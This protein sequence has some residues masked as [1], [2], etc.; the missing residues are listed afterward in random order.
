MLSA[1]E[2][3]GLTPDNAHTQILGPTGPTVLGLVRVSVQ[4]FGM[5]HYD[6]DFIVGKRPRVF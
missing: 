3:H 6:Y 5:Q 4:K 2:G 1:G